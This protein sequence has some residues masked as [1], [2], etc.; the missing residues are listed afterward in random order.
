MCTLGNVTN[1]RT[2]LAKHFGKS[3]G[4][5]ICMNGEAE[6]VP[7]HNHEGTYMVDW[8]TAP[9]ILNLGIRL[10]SVVSF[11]PCLLYIQ[12]PLTRRPSDSQT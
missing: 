10:R 3:A 12:H 11:T 5:W 2:N 8:E 4:S 1:V 6:A 9:L 7:V